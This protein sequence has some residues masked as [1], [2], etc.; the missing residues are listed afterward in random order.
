M[1]IWCDSLK[2]P[3][4]KIA[5]RV[6][7]SPEKGGWRERARRVAGLTLLSALLTGC[8][9]A[10]YYA[11]A[12]NGHLSLMAAARPVT[13]VIADPQTSDALRQRLA[14]SQ[15][16]RRFAV[17]ELLLPDNASYHR[18]ADL[19]RPSAVW[20]VVA[21]PPDALVAKTWCYP[22]IGCASYRGYFSEAE[23]RA[24]AQ[25]LQAEGL[26]VIV[27]GVPAYSTLGWLNWAGGDPLLNTFINYPEGELARLVFHELSHQLIYV[28]DDSSFNEAFATAVERLGG[29][30]WLALH[31]SAAAREADAALEARRQAFRG[32]VRQTRGE[33]AAIFEKKST[34]PSMDR[35]YLAMKKEVM[36]G[37][38]A[39]YAAL[40]AGWGGDPAAY[41][42]L[43][44]WVSGA[45][46][47]SFVSQ[48]TYDE[49][50]PGFMR[51]FERE[52][53]DT[54]QGWR[55]FYDAVNQL[56]GLSREERRRA[57]KE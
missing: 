21:A 48:A 30:R 19:H 35:S 9:S 36:D 33:L 39:R 2:P 44:A 5:P 42:R 50:V 8:T 54:P 45:N 43:D 51:L 53:G 4:S 25:A 31:G 40:R 13:E 23:A 11:Q 27:Q 37:F 20:S 56:A 52:G 3:Q 7:P 17:N 28:R 10:G 57:L 32:L 6:R 1:L 46:N 15:D 47:A 41:R 18:Y 34:D 12:V 16:I 14:Q 38:R 24:E 26:E 55:R 49:L 29:R 22:V